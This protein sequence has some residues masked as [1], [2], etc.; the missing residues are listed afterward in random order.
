MNLFCCLIW[1]LSLE[2]G[3]RGGEVEGNYSYSASCRT[4]ALADGHGGVGLCPSSKDSTALAK[5][6]LASTRVQE[7]KTRVYQDGENHSAEG[8]QGRWRGG[9]KLEWSGVGYCSQ[10][11]PNKTKFYVNENTSL[12]VHDSACYHHSRSPPKKQQKCVILLRSE[13]CIT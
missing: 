12:L 13:I 2:T 7:H 9:S 11:H 3:G 10:A 6:V 8:N 4:C 5:K 1:A